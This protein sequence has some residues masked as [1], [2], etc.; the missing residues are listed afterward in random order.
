MKLYAQ[1]KA[2]PYDEKGIKQKVIGRVEVESNVGILSKADVEE[3]AKAKLYATVPSLRS[4][5]IEVIECGLVEEI[6]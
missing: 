4:V 3:L 2:F 6:A 1:Y 5:P